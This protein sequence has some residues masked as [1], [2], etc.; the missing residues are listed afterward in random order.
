MENRFTSVRIINEKPRKVIVDRDRNIISK[1]PSKEE[2]KGLEKEPYTGHKKYTESQLLE[3]LRKFEREN[4]RVS[5][6]RDFMNNP[7]Y[8]SSWMYY[9]RFVSC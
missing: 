1:N 2:L 4:G 6:E 8:P 7:E 3:F 5:V 9:D